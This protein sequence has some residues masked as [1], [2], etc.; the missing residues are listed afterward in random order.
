MGMQVPCGVNTEM[1]GEV[2]YGE[3]GKNLG[4]VLHG[5]ARQKGSQ[6]EYERIG[7]LDLT[8]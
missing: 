6:K 7:F 4:E 5:L 2:R 1:L 8:L 3:L